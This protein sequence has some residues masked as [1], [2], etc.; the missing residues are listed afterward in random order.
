[1]NYYS[2]ADIERIGPTECLT[3]MNE[4]HEANSRL[5]DEIERLSAAR[6]SERK[7]LAEFDRL[8]LLACQEVERIAPIAR[9]SSLLRWELFLL[10]TAYNG[11]QERFAKDREHLAALA[12]CARDNNWQGVSEGLH[13]Y[14]WQAFLD[15]QVGKSDQIRRW[16]SLWKQV[17]KRYFP[18][19]HASSEKPFDPYGYGDPH[20]DPEYWD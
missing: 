14:A 9:E 15:T 17:A 18:R 4:L 5:G 8:R 11:L 13:A 12:G 20:I 10:N 2:M 3:H 6:E 1:M 19:D 16:A 7:A